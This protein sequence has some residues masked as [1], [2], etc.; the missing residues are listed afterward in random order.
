MPLLELPSHAVRIRLPEPP[1]VGDSPGGTAAPSGAAGGPAGSGAEA[2]GISGSDQATV[3]ALDGE[4][5]RAP[6][7]VVARISQDS[8]HLDVIALE[9]AEVEAVADSVAWAIDRL[10][11][12]SL[13]T[14]G[15]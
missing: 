3:S 15:T 7:P 8:L 9:E 1:V 2:G 10:A 14:F 5:R 13:D 11:G 6:V 12:R 4:L